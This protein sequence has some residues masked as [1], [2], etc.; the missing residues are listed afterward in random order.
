VVHHAS[1]YALGL[2]VSNFSLF[3]RKMPA[4]FV[5]WIVMWLPNP[6]SSIQGFGSNRVPTVRYYT[7][8]GLETD[9]FF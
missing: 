5:D 4:A 9:R 3:E 1:S 7:A 2:R 8:G 6:D